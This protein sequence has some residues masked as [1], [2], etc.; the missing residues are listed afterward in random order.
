MCTYF[1][2]AYLTLYISCML[3]TISCILLK[4]IIPHMCT[5]VYEYTI[6]LL[7]IHICIRI[8]LLLLINLVVKLNLQVYIYVYNYSY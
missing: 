6:I 8:L 3:Y 7:V 5:P 1:I 2:Y 4:L